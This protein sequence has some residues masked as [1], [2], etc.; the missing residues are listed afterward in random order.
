[1]LVRRWLGMVNHLCIELDTELNQPP[2]SCGVPQSGD[3]S[4]LEIAA[5]NR[6]TRGIQ[7]GNVGVRSLT[8]VASGCFHGLEFVHLSRRLGEVDETYVVPRE[9]NRAGARAR[10]R[11][12]RQHR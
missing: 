3:A 6:S 2:A 4:N 9:G 1:M 11:R 7:I 5:P 12:L 8:R 10:L